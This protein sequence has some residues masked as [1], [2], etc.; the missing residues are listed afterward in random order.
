MSLKRN[1]LRS[2]GRWVSQNNDASA[3]EDMALKHGLG[4][5]VFLVT[6][7]LA[8]DTYSLVAVWRILK[9]SG[10]GCPTLKD[11]MSVT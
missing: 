2:P 1:C 9:A 11:P 6:S 8:T 5:P 7:R 3:S 4:M 10:F